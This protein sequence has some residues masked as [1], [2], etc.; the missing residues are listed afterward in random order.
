[1]QCRNE[2]GSNWEVYIFKEAYLVIIKRITQT[3]SRHQCEINNELKKRAI[4]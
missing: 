4:R 1:M 2:V 3:A